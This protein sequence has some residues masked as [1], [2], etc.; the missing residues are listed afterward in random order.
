M[1]ERAAARD[2]EV[3]NIQSA[4]RS[5]PFLSRCSARVQ[6]FGR[7][8]W[9]VTCKNKREAV[10]TQPVTLQADTKALSQPS[11]VPLPRHTQT[12][13]PSTPLLPISCLHWNYIYL[14]GIALLPST[15]SGFSMLSL[16]Q[17]LLGA[18][19]IPATTASTLTD[20]SCPVSLLQPASS[21]WL[22]TEAEP[23]AF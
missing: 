17:V 9:R 7:R 23:F 4:A 5:P 20:D 11:A 21:G 14:P 6:A 22:I 10:S 3:T 8:Y 2:Y 13:A 16:F 15:P 19:Q 18:S 1:R 12:Q